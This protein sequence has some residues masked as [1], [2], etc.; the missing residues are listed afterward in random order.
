MP[1]GTLIEYLTFGRFVGH[2]D[3]SGITQYQESNKF[4]LQHID[5]P[6]IQVIG[7]PFWH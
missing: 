6:I 7:T 4:S 3:I 1:G 5:A 2:F